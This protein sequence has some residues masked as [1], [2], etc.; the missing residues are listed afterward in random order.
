MMPMFSI[1]LNA[2][3]RLSSPCSS[4]YNAPPSADSS[5]RP[6]S[7]YP[8]HAAGSASH[9]KSTRM[10]P[11][12]ATLSITADISAEMCAGATGCARGS[13]AWNGARPALVPNPTIAAVAT[14]AVGAPAA[15][16]PLS[17]PWAAST[18]IATHTP[19]PPMCVTAR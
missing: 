9:W 15:S 13:Q 3:R 4:A 2:S 14:S 17:A 5:P 12:S 16:E 18:S 10:S 11:Y 19:A 6:S 7:A 1:E 8:T